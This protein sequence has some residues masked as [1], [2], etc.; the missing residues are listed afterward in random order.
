M[1]T[2]LLERC[3]KILQDH[4][5]PR[6]WRLVLYGSMARNEG[7]AASDIDLLV[8]LDGQFDYFQELRTITDLLYP[9]QLESDRLISAKPADRGEFEGGRLQFYRN[10]RRE[11]VPL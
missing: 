7:T 5:G 10:A 11:G 4:Y 1:D 3:K 8:L 2:L 6:F 9:L